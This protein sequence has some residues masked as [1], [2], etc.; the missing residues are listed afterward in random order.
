MENPPVRSRLVRCCCSLGLGL[1]FTLLTGCPTA[2]PD[3]DAFVLKGTVTT[4]D[5]TK[6]NGVDIAF[7]F[8]KAKSEPRVL[9]NDGEFMATLPGGSAVVYFKYRKV[10]P[11]PKIPDPIPEGKKDYYDEKLREWDAKQAAVT[12]NIPEKYLSF[13]TSP[14]KFDVPQKG[15]K[16]VEWTLENE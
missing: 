5:G 6:V 16:K 13:K 12:K 15:E 8:D 3:R 9:V 14:L 7:H 2:V 4:A 11:K 1:V 10:E